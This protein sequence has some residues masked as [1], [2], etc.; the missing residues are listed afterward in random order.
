[1]LTI[2]WQKGN[3]KGYWTTID[4]WA[5]V[6]MLHFAIG[7]ILIKKTIYKLYD[8]DKTAVVYI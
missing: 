8:L 5:N 2:I 6:C 3:L 1:M 4:K 7:Y